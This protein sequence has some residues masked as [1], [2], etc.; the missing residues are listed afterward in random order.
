MASQYHYS[1][2]HDSLY[3]GNCVLDGT[4]IGH[5]ALVSNEQLID[6]LGGI[7]VNLLK[8]LLDVVE[9]IHVSDIVHNADAVGATVVR[10][11][12]GS[13]SLLAGGIPLS[14]VSNAPRPSKNHVR[15][16]A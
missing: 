6:T 3:L 9:G 2:N 16:G 1:N 5:I 12:D 7:S 10:G 11:R 8:P 13:E 15:S 4:L 14:L